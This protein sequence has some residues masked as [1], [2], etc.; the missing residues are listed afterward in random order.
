MQSRIG[1]L[2][3]EGCADAF[4]AQLRTVIQIGSLARGEGTFVPVEG[5]TMLLGDA[6]FLLL[7]HDR[8][9]LPPAGR[10]ALV[11]SAVQARLGREGLRAAVQL[12]PCHARYLRSLEPHVFAYEIKASGRPIWGDPGALSLVPSYSAEQIPREDAWRLLCNRLIEQ[13]EPLSVLSWPCASV[14]SVVR[15]RTAKLYLDMATSFLIFAGAYAPS[16]RERALALRRLAAR[17][18]T[19]VECPLPLAAFASRV[20]ACTRYKLE[21]TGGEEIGSW[22]EWGEAIDDARALWRWELA[23]LTEAREEASERALRERWRR[24][25]PARAR[26]RGW[27]HVLRSRGWHRS[28]R[29]WRRWARLAVWSSPR[30]CVYAAGT[31]LLFALPGRLAGADASDIDYAELRNSLPVRVGPSDRG[32]E[33]PWQEAAREVFFNYREFLVGT[34]S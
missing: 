9:P 23:R 11:E 32:A 27:L 1:A 16:Y 31:E 15:Y 20:E 24:R 28:W 5:G 26:L 19:A 3:A 30:L 13:L 18:G 29:E 8:F 14:P 25:Q 12:S 10:V 4:G 6:E 21:G 7:F 22:A 34:R 33:A 17:G 2:V